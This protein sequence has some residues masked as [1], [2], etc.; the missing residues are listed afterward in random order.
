MS[1]SVTYPAVLPVA[2]ETVLFVSRL[3]AA[4]R[5]IGGSTAYSHRAA[6]RPHRAQP[7]PP[8]PATPGFF[9]AYNE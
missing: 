1:V 4:E 9:S 8:G 7:D 3:L 6:A 2:E 5:R